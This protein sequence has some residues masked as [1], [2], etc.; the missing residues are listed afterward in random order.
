[1]E[2][3][4]TYWFGLQRTQYNLHANLSLKTK[5]FPSI[6]IFTDQEEK[7]TYSGQRDPWTWTIDLVVT[8]E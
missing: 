4:A 1:M 5:L 2:I 6:S 8:R 3:Q 7:K